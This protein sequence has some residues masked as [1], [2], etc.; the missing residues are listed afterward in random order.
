M[1]G[2]PRDPK[3]APPEDDDLPEERA[4]GGMLDEAA[5]SKIAAEEEKK[6]AAARE[7]EMV[8]GEAPPVGD[9]KMRA[10][11]AEARKKIEDEL[12]AKRKKRRLMRGG[13]V[14]R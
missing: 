6:K 1:F 14:S 5:Y 7:A 13:D 11:K 2:Q 12:I 8:D 9:E 3:P 4:A 10:L